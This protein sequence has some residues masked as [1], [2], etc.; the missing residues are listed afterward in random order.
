MTGNGHA[1]LVPGPL[2]NGPEHALVGQLGFLA[3][4]FAG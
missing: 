4:G 2:A 1:L 3:E